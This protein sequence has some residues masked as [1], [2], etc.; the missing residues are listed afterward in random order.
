V[1][2]NKQTNKQTHSRTDVT[3]NNPLRYCIAARVYRV[4]KPV[5]ADI[6]L[7]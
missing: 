7:K 3:E 1:L 5:G 2:T 6:T 4:I